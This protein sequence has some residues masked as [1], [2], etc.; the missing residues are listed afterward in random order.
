M[1]KELTNEQKNAWSWLNSVVKAIK[2]INKGCG[3]IYSLQKIDVF[4]V[5]PLIDWCELLEIPYKRVD[6]D[7]NEAC[8]SDWDEVYFVYK[9]IR[10]FELVSKVDKETENAGE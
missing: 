8:E 1:R 4:Q 7:G 2:T 9:G 6:W 10:F 5:H 3:K